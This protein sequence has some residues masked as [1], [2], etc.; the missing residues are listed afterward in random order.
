MAIGWTVTLDGVTLSGGDQPGTGCLTL[1]PDGLGLPEIRDNDVVYAQR[2]GVRHFSDWYE[3][4]IVTLEVT[5]GGGACR[6]CG[7]ERRAVADI[8]K[9]WSRKCDD[10]ELVVSPPCEPD[11]DDRTFTGP[12]GILGRPRMASVEWL[13]GRRGVAKLLLRFDAAD[14]RM[15]LL[16]PDGTP[17]SGVETVGLDPSTEGK[18]RC[19]PRCYD[20]TWCYDTETG[21]TVLPTEVEVQGTE[22]VYPVICFHGTLTNP[23]LENLTTGESVGYRGTITGEDV[24]CID[25]ETGTAELDGASRTHLITGNPRM[26]LDPGPNLLRLVS[27]SP[28]DSGHVEISWRP[29]VVSG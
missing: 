26:T 7:D 4:R 15:F 25:T 23:V 19:Y 6:G 3:P 20:P 27:Y 22:C 17:G 12:Y 8:V 18:V 29:I 11:P 14:H 2:D 13:R 10:V 16:D 9:A 21:N 24:I 5:V 1:P 28:T